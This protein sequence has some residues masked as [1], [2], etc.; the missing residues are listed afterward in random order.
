VA[1]HLRRVPGEE[2]LAIVRQNPSVLEG[3]FE[4]K[5]EGILQGTDWQVVVRE[6]GGGF[7][8]LRH[9]KDMLL[10]S[11]PSVQIIHAQKTVGGFVLVDQD[12]LNGP[13]KYSAQVSKPALKVECG[14]WG[15]ESL[16]D[17]EKAASI[18]LTLGPARGRGKR[19]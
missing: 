13:S 4:S 7:L 11:D 9:E 10:R 17:A 1:R 16:A 18:C 5:P 15:L 2:Y 19:H 6:P 12:N 8:T 3:G 14:A